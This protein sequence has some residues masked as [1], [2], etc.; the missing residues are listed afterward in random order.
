MFLTLHSLAPVFRRAALAGAFALLF[1]AAAPSA[2]QTPAPAARPAAPPA[3]PAAAAP[4]PDGPPPALILPIACAMGTDCWVQSYFDHD[5]GARDIDYT[6]GSATYG[7]HLGT[8]FRVADL[9]AMARGVPVVASAAGV[10]GGARDGMEDISMRDAP[11]PRGRECG[12]GVRVVHGGGWETQYCHLRKGSVAV[13]TGDAVKAGDQLGLVGLS[14]NTEFPH[15]HL[16]VTFRRISVDPFVGKTVP[17]QCGQSRTPLFTPAAMA[18]LRYAPASVINGGFSAERPNSIG[19]MMGKFREPEFGADEEILFFWIEY[20]NARAG[21]R[22]TVRITMPNGQALPEDAGTVD[23][24]LARRMAFWGKQLTPRRPWP[25]GTYTG[26]FELQREIDG[27]LQTIVTAERKVEV[28]ASAATVAAVS[29]APSP[30]ASPVP[31]VQTAPLP[32]PVITGQ[33]P[34]PGSSASVVVTAPAPQN[35]LGAEAAP[36]APTADGGAQEPGGRLQALLRER[37]AAAPAPSTAPAA[38]PATSGMVAAVTAA[39]GAAATQAL[40]RVRV[41][42]RGDESPTPSGRRRRGPDSWMLGLILLG[43]LAVMA[44]AFLATY[45][46]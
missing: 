23:R 5:P 19:T 41:L 46:R 35:T 30:P 42:V 8:D 38:P 45:R 4:E 25:T 32:T 10:V 33:L 36:A 11:V 7:A 44:L 21:D 14:G 39:A 37:S 2:A 22:E 3:A 1:A 15:V 40:D 28:R 18:Q 43:T 16:E 26:R 20:I 31:P 24:N 6:C 34:A 12:N 17:Y 13:K 9:A 27:K 29:A